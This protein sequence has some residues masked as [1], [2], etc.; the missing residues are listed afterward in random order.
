[1]SLTEGRIS[2]LLKRATGKLRES[3]QESPLVSGGWQQSLG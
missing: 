1:M 2:Q 3:L